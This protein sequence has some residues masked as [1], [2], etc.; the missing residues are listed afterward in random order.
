MI[1]V[2]QIGLLQRDEREGVARSI[3]IREASASG[4]P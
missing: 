1:A 3:R 4:Q 2:N